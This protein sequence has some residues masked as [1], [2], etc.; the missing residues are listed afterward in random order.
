[1]TANGKLDRTRLPAPGA[2]AASRAPRTPREEILCAVFADVLGVS[3]VGIDDGFF[4]RGGHSLLAT[5]LVSR[6]RK[7]LG[8][9]LPLRVL[10][11][12]PT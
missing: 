6:V 7:A 9:E 12:S 10:F 8:V 11:E 2:R 3:E 5:R 4:E 1:M